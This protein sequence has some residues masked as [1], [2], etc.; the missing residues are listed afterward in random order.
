MNIKAVCFWN[1][2]RCPYFTGVKEHGTRCQI[3]LDDYSEFG[4]SGEHLT[5]N[6]FEDGFV[7]IIKNTYNYSEEEWEEKI[8]KIL[9][10]S[11]IEKLEENDEF[12]NLKILVKNK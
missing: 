7:C 5:L 1:K 9:S 11:E 6:L 12:V 10:K 8:I 4:V 3:S 2:K